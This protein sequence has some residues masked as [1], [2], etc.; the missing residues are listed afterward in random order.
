M[1]QNSFIATKLNLDKHYTLLE[2]RDVTYLLN[3]DIEGYESS[4]QNDFVQNQKSNELC[5]ELPS[6]DQFVGPGISVGSGQHVFFTLGETS[7]IILSNLDECSYEVLASG[8]CLGF[9]LDYPI[10]GVYKYNSQTNSRRIYFIDGLNFDRYLD[11]DKSFPQTRTTDDCVTCERVYDGTLDCDQ[12]KIN[13]DITV[14]CV[15]L[16]GNNQG[17]LS[18]GVY[19]IGFAW[20]QDGII[21][22]DFYWSDVIKVWSDKPN[23]GLDITLDCI[24]TEVFNEFTLVLVTNTREG[25]TVLYRLGDYQFPTS[26]V[27][28]TNLSNSTVVDLTVATQKK[29]INDKSSHITTNGEILLLGSSQSSNLIPYQKQAN[30]IQIY[31]Q[32]FKVPKDQAHLYP[33]FMRDE[34]YDFA[35]RWFKTPGQEVGKFHIPGRETNDTYSYTSNGLD[36]AITYKEYDLVP[37]KYN[38]YSNPDCEEQE[39]YA[40]QITSTAYTVGDF[41]GTCDECITGTQLGKYGGM[42]YY[43]CLDLTYPDD[44][45][46]WGDLACQ[47]IRRHRMP[48]HNITHLYESGGCQ[49]QT[50]EQVDEDGNFET[51]TGTSFVEG[52]CV[53]LLGIRVEGITPPLDVDGNPIPDILGFQI[54]YSKRDGNK[55]ILH[56]GLMFS[57]RT[58]K[59][60]E[61][62]GN[63]ET[64]LFPNYPFNDLKRDLYLGTQ[65]ARNWDLPESGVLAKGLSPLH[66]TYHSPDVLFK[67]AKNEF[68]S[69]LR[70]YTAEIGGIFGSINK[71][72][73]HPEQSIY[74]EDGVVSAAYLNNYANTVN[75]IANFGKFTT[76]VRDFEESWLINNSQYL[77]PIR[78][79]FGNY[80]V[81]NLYRE[82]SYMVEIEPSQRIFNQYPRQQD[83]GGEDT[84]RVLASNFVDNTFWN[85]VNIPYCSNVNIPDLNADPAQTWDIQAVSN[86][87]GIKI[88]QPNQYGQIGSTVLTPVSACIETGQVSGESFAFIGGDI[89]I[90]KHAA[91]RKMPLYQDWLYDVPFDTLVDYR[92]NRNVWYPRFW[93]DNQT[94]DYSVLYRFDNR[95]Q[96]GSFVQGRFYTHVNGVAWFWCESEFIGNYRESD[97]RDNTQFYPNQSLPE[98]TRSDKFKLEPIWLYDFSLLSDSIDQSRLSSLVGLKNSLDP[99]YNLSDYSVNYS[100]K[101]DPQSGY[102]NWLTFLPLNYTILPRIYGDFTG[103]RYI[104]QYSVLF[105]FENGTLHSQEDYTLTINQG[106]SLFLAQGDIFSRRL[107]KWSNENSGYTG[108]VDPFFHINTR[109]GL[110]YF[111]RYRKTFF[112]WTDQLQP[113]NDLKTF[114]NNFSDQDNVGY[115]NSMISVYDNLTDK[116]YITDK[117]RGWTI[118]FSPKNQ[119]FIS[120]HSFVPDWYVPHYNTYLSIKNNSLWKHN[121]DGYQTYYGSN[122]PFEIEFVLKNP[123]D[124][125]LQDISLFVDYIDYEGYNQIVQRPDKFFNKA[126]V[127]NNRYSTGLLNLDLKNT[128]NPQIIQNKEEVGVAEV[129]QVQENI[130]RINKLENNQVDSPNLSFNSNGV[131]YTI[132]NINQNKPTHQKSLLKGRWFKAHFI[133]DENTTSKILVQLNLSQTDDTKK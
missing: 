58:E 66:Y 1:T 87:V 93:F 115:S 62:G 61:D 63:Q 18:S 47:K 30:N 43:E 23:V 69:E 113:V 86:Y 29:V 120:F 76:L 16:E 2:D 126:F 107:R 94:L 85:D 6:G 124:T 39:K 15:S 97:F 125:N 48:S 26:N 79:F 17:Q 50:I 49:L 38:I 104:D 12:L 3:G 34:V 110:F 129:S 70:L 5:F 100:L 52:D 112:M 81:N 103:M 31:W 46:I 74:K 57:V 101:D 37:A 55:S 32:E 51:V 123:V 131:T 89:Y 27:T 130:Y 71:L 45:S 108:S 88:P 77:L 22:S 13:K 82:T 67:E 56:K 117:Q 60:G 36:G 11:I 116:I 20:S 83:S 54:M 4:N 41:G 53:N 44:V 90:S 111:D 72:Y 92:D 114:L 10:R 73:K 8:D 64:I 98:L 99:D 14:P 84:S 59:I 7:K 65:E 102:D 78:Q 95:Y 132:Q 33:C 40:W 121:A 28:V 80:K 106:N 42:G 133:D 122:Y 21:L 96:S 9:D 75:L 25:A 91:V 128:D 109:Y 119:G 68:G 118:S 127:Y 105:E 24:N 35:I 19:Q